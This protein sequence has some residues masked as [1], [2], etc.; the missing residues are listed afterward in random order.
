M[1]V[2]LHEIAHG[3]MA[4]RCGDHTAEMAGRLSLNPIHHIDPMFTIVMPLLTLAASGGQFIFG[5]AKPVPVNP[6]NFRNIEID[7]LKVSVAGVV[8]NLAIAIA[9]GLTL[10][11]WIP[12]SLGY[13]LFTLVTVANLFLAFFN[14]VPIP[15]LDGSHVARFF[16]AKVS[17]E[18]AATYERIGI[19]GFILIIFF[20]NRFQLPIIL[21]MD[22]VWSRVLFIDT[23]WYQVIAE[24]RQAF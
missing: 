9:C 15:P 4:R 8:T 7:D 20:V 11:V 12:G 5:G 16:I 19:F 17:P 10:H 13:T 18:I 3:W 24:F 6:Y 23:H 1:S 22:F 14:L 21:A 2:I